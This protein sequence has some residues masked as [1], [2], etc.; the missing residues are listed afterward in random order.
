MTQHMREREYSTES[1]QN[2]TTLG[3]ARQI[4]SCLNRGGALVYVMNICD[5][6]FCRD[7]QRPEDYLPTTSS[8]QF[9]YQQQMAIGQAYLPHQ[10]VSI[11][12]YKNTWP[13]PPTPGGQ[14]TSI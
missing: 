2:K 13:L 5:F 11:L 1:K 6:T 4:Q 3:K 12:V 10:E 14:Y 7:Y 9:Y 8:Q